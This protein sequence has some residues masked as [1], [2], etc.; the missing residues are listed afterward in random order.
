MP[1]CVEA[2][3]R[4]V[5][6]VLEVDPTQAAVLARS[7]QTLTEEADNPHQQ[8][9]SVLLLGRALL[10]CSEL[11]EA[12]QNLLRAAD[13]YRDLKDNLGQAEAE[14]YAGKVY[15]NLGEFEEA[16]KHLQSAIDR[17]ASLE[18]SKARKV[19]AT[20]LNHLAGAQH[21]QGKAGEAL[22]LLHRALQIWQQEDNVTGQVQCLGN[23]GNVQTWL[24]QYKEAVTTLSKAYQLYTAQSQDTR[25]E[26][27]IL[28]NLAHVH[29]LS[30]DNTLA[31]K[32]ME[33]A[34]EVALAGQDKHIQATVLLN[35]G[36]FCL[37]AHRPEQSQRYLEEALDLSRQIG[38]Q[39]GE[40]NAL[41]SL[42]SLY[43]QTGNPE[44]ACSMHQEAL[45]I[46]LSIGSTQGELDA[47]LHL[48]R[49]YL[50]RGQTGAALEELRTTLDLAVRAQFPKEAAAAHEAL[51]T[52]F[53]QE[54]RYLEALHHSEELRRIEREL[55]DAERDRQT[56]NLTIQFEV[57]RARHDA[58]VYRMRTEVEQ[59]ARHAAE[60]QVRERTEELARAQHEVV[61][62]LAIAAEYRDDSTGEHTRRVGRLA[63]RIA[64][65]LGWSEQRA[66]TLGIAARLHDVGKIGIP[67]SVLLKPGRLDA[68]EYARMQEHTLIGA[69]I[70]SG[71]RSELLRLA[72][73]IALTHHER[74]DGKGYP[75]GL[76]GDAIPLTGRIVAVADVY[77]ALTQAR[78]YKPAWTHE[79]A[80][81]ELQAQAGTQFDPWVVHA[82][83][84]V[85]SEPERPE[86]ARSPHNPC[87]LEDPSHFDDA[88]PILS[89]FEQLL[90]ARTRERALELARAE[91]SA[92]GQRE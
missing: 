80:M 29:H 82:A 5:L 53:K 33:S 6:E 49:L 52:L 64:R 11:P 63:A 91:C 47:R 1:L 58:D 43:E 67:D 37:E 57:E 89:V 9:S 48:G 46:A 25:T 51:A 24:G 81:R 79:E 23:I 83:L 18:T 42:G 7:C 15:L 12:L 14:C 45:S 65:A 17:T 77:D 13:L 61:T 26:A 68:E 34:H 56:R 87:P 40:L 4:A 69:R 30:G 84:A 74:W 32:V 38:Y 72:Q 78:P 22:H 70:L 44:L 28:H 71:G 76:Q 60:M 8:A 39:I 3:Q 75:Q 27:S 10:A 16:Q 54:G 88:S 20:A 55:F 59:E 35:L 21:H 85:L 86:G 50:K 73:E 90:A 31:I 66:S 41:D 62:R 19:Q 2:L 92:E 36:V